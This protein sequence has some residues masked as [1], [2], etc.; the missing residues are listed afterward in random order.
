MVTEINFKFC[1]GLKGI[2]IILAPCDV[3]TLDKLDKTVKINI[4]IKVISRDIHSI[5]KYNIIITL[6]L[7]QA[8]PLPLGEMALHWAHSSSGQMTPRLPTLC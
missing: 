3:I 8:L 1:K 5:T 6:L 4:S 7:L 2:K